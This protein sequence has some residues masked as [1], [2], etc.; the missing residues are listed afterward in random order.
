MCVSVR[1]YGGMNTRTCSLPFACLLVTL[2]ALSGCKK[3]EKSAQPLHSTT[4]EVAQP[5]EGKAPNKPANGPDPATPP[6]APP[7]AATSAQAPAPATKPYTNFELPQVATGGRQGAVATAHPLA[8]RAAAKALHDGG[9]AVDALVAASFV[10]TV[11]RPQSTGIGG[12]GFAVVLPPNSTEAR[13]FDF[14]ET[15]PR[16]GNVKMYLDKDGRHVAKLSQRH[17]LAIGVPGYVKGLWV[18]HKKYGKRPW[19]ELVQ[20]GADIARRGFRVSHKLAGAIAVTWAKLGPNAQ[21]LLKRKDGEALRTGDILLQP[22]LAVT[23]DRI[24][25][26]GLQ[27]FYEGIVAADIIDAART[28]GGHLDHEDMRIYKVKESVALSGTWR[29]NV[30]WTMPQPSA[31]GAQILAMA[32]LIDAALKKS[33]IK[34]GKGVAKA[35]TLDA[36]PVMHALI[37]AMRRS[38][39]LR[40]AYSGDPDDKATK[41]SD[42]YPKKVRA[43]MA[44]SFNPAKATVSARIGKSGKLS[45]SDNTS[46][47]S[48]IDED[49]LAVSSTHT[50][51]LLFG[52]G[53]LAP[54]AGV[55]LNNELDDFS[56]TLKDSNA[57]G[58]AGSKANLYQPGRRP[59]SSM[60][61]L[62]VTRANKPILVMG[63]PGG[64]RIPT[65]VF[66]AAYRH[67]VDGLPLKEA[68]D[69]PRLHN[70]AFPDHT[71]VEKVT[72]SETKHEALHALGHKTVD[73]SGWC[74]VE[75]VQAEWDEKGTLRSLTAASDRRDE[76]GSMVLK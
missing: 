73:R 14:R 52:S 4:A 42:V 8:T 9:T 58:L 27:G 6:A 31:G 50:I 65:A 22:K 11:V 25:E 64:T 30:V 24:A 48:I 29:G 36:P 35:L 2:T 59:V 60:S 67:L 49:G 21:K 15:G 33:K 56:Y 47:V 55:F 7:A 63:A 75:A 70:Q 53:I 57:F 32:E 39:L 16:L 13:A 68:V 72:G 54:E 61:P 34:T 17:G 76:G 43:A 26:E 3:T 51:N 20:P 46:H 1:D 69:G 45:K 19:A 66:Q 37:E 62:I 71:W 23:L 5:S 44:A 40:L 18:L 41:L 12:G 74:D 10:L 28:N 38:F